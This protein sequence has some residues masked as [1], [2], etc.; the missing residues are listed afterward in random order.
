VSV[1]LA[2]NVTNVRPLSNLTN[3]QGPFMQY[4]DNVTG[5]PLLGN[6]YNGL[7][8]TNLTL[9]DPHVTDRAN[10]VQQQLASAVFQYVVRSATGLAGANNNTFLFL[11]ETVYVSFSPDGYFTCVS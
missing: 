4:A 1:D 11:T 2:S 10:A 5:V 6:A 9:D 7:N 3:G 8:W